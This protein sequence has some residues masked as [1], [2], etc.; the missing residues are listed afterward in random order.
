MRIA[1]SIFLTV[2]C[3][4]YVIWLV[5]LLREVSDEVGAMGALV[6]IFT[7]LTFSELDELQSEL[8]NK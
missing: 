4:T 5:S 1:L 7:Y 8:K 3:G 6:G 2:G